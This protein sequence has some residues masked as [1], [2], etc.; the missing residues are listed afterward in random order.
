MTHSF[1]EMREICPSKSLFDPPERKLLL[2]EPRTKFKMSFAM[3]D[4]MVFSI[5]KICMKSSSLSNHNEVCLIQNI[6]K[7]DFKPL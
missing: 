6:L 5:A 1:F 2:L 4:E 3:H 7:Y